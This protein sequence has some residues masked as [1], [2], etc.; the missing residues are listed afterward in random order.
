MAKHLYTYVNP[1]S[2]KHIAQAC[3]Y[4]RNEGV[5]A[6][7]SDVNWAI[8]W[9]PGCKKALDKVRVLKPFHPKEQSFSLLCDS[10]TMISKVGYLE[11]NHYRLLKKVLPGPYTILLKKNHP[12]AFAQDD[13]LLFW[14]LAVATA[15]TIFTI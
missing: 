2:D 1:T 8:A 15:T 5:I 10:F 11:A 12:S 3:D 9:D 6:Y 7:P 13:S 4:L 14:L